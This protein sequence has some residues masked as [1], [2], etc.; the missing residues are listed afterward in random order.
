MLVA[1]GSHP[2]ISAVVGGNYLQS[3]HH[4]GKPVFIKAEPVDYV[5]GAPVLVHCYFWE[6]DDQFCGWWFRSAVGHILTWAFNPQ[7]TSMPPRV[8]W[9]A[10]KNAETDPNMVLSG[11]GIG[12]CEHPG[13]GEKA[14]DW[15]QQFMCGAHCH[16]TDKW[17]SRHNSE[18][19][20]AKAKL[21]RPERANRRRGGKRVWQG[22]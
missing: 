7:A 13:C 6:S 21:R 15:C 10:T 9:Q 18:Q 19:E 12:I 11:D 1:G 8:G 16:L 5:N 14:A 2:E 20:E 17:C 22:Y 4:H 3:G